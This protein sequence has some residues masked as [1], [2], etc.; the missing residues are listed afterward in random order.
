MLNPDTFFSIQI[1]CPRHG[2]SRCLPF[3]L[4]CHPLRCLDS[5]SPLLCEVWCNLEKHSNQL[6]GESDIPR[7]TLSHMHLPYSFKATGVALSLGS[8]LT[9]TWTLRLLKPQKHL[10]ILL[11]VFISKFVSPES[12]TLITCEV[13]QVLAQPWDNCRGLAWA[14]D[15]DSMFS[16]KDESTAWE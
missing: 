16:S 5:W 9:A 14:K 10:Y 11:C 3:L 13:E 7:L 1:G 4:G 6:L 8:H 15:W 2:Q 12:V